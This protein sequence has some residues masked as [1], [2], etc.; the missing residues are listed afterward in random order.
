[1]ALP[2]QER[3]DLFSFLPSKSTLSCILE[4]WGEDFHDKHSLAGDHGN[5]F[6]T[7]VPGADVCVFEI[8]H[9]KQS[10]FVLSHIKHVWHSPIIWLCNF[11]SKYSTYMLCLN[12]LCTQTD[13][14]CG[15]GFVFGFLVFLFL[16]S[17]PFWNG[18]Y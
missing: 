4:W 5:I 2:W 6:L 10:L 18:S 8:M 1:M 11:C 12:S 16:L 9:H 15:F 14:L 17:C 3:L 7:A 13:T